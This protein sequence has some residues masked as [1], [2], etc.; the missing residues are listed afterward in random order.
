MTVP[1]RRIHT[2]RFD[3][4][5][6]EKRIEGIRQDLTRRVS[7]RGDAFAMEVTERPFTERRVAGGVWL[8]KI[9]LAVLERATRDWTI[10]RIGGFD[11]TCSVRRTLIGRNCGGQLL[12]QR[13]Q[14]E[15]PIEVGDDLTPLGLIARL[16]STLIGSRRIWRNSSGKKTDAAARLK[17]YEPRLGEPFPLQ[18]ELDEK[19]T[20]M[21]ELTADLAKTGTL[22]EA[23]EGDGRGTPPEYRANFK[24]H[25]H[26]TPHWQG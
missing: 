17:G 8:S 2:A 23:N 19:L 10:G 15:Q 9:R 25:P 4:Q 12:L 6:A 14:F 22:I 20:R 7:T 16:E 24:P 5:S 11:V 21:A 26:R 3:Q 18:G 13:T 1:R